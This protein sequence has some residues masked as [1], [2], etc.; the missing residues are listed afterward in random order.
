MLMMSFWSSTRGLP[1]MV[2]GGGKGLVAMGTQPI[3]AA[4]AKGSHAA[5]EAMF[6][7]MLCYA[8][9]RADG[10]SRARRRGSGGCRG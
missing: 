7:A 3:A 8:F 10:E 1:G 9:G 4:R 6:G 5:T 2:G